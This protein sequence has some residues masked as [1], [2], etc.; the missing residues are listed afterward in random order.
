MQ[1]RECELGFGL[2]PH[3]AQDRDSV[4]AI[5]C[6][7]EQRRLSDPRLPPQDEDTAAPGASVIKKAVD[8]LGLRTS[9]D[10]HRASDRNAGQTG[11]PDW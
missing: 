10:E 11:A 5:S 4:R 2:D 6:I 1:R 3:P 7:L 8:R 9:A